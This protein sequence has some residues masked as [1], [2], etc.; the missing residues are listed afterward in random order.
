MVKKLEPNAKNFVVKSNA[1]VE[2]R[3][4]LSLQESQVILWLLTQIHPNDEDFKAHR[5]D[6]VEFARLTQ[7]ESGNRYSELRRITKQLMQRVMEIY[8]PEEDKTIQVAWL[9]STEYEH[10]KGF[11]SLEFSPKLKPYL[12][13]LKGHFT[14]IDIVD[15]L[16]LKSIYAI[17]I[18]EL[19]LQ[20]GH[21][22]TREISIAD[23]RAY[24][25]VEKTEYLL[26]ADLK[27][28]AINKAKMEINSKT[29][30]LIDYK[31]IKESRKVIALEWTIKK[32]NLQKDQDLKK[33]TVIQKEIRSEALLVETLMEYGFSKGIAKR[34]VISHGEEVVKNALKAVNIQM[35]RKQAR[36]PKAMLQTAIQEKWHPEIYKKKLSY[37]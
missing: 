12:L 33:L 25:G 26:Y 13:Q 9:S 18:F 28:K 14:K 30:Y 27:R 23:L 11:V 34:L 17:R 3:Y 4:R 5:L 16:K 1:L 10:K 37:E 8:S 7:V 35:E 24:C 29:E 31:E 32:K 2:A 20:Y 6:I 21:I 19:L 36:N 22:G 15:T